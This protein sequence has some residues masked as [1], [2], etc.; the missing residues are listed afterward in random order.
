M[1]ES[2]NDIRPTTPSNK[3]SIRKKSNANF[4]NES[5]RVPPQAVDFEEAVLGAL[6]LEKN[7]I[8]NNIFLDSYG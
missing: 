3:R 5:G 7:A 8:I 1:D 2:S 6:M 4:Y